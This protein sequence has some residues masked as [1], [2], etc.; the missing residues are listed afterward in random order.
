MSDFD[1]QQLPGLDTDTPTDQRETPEIESSVRKRL[2]PLGYERQHRLVAPTFRTQSPDLRRET[3]PPKRGDEDPLNTGLPYDK[4][5]PDGW[6]P[7]TEE[8]ASRRDAIDPQLRQKVER[9]VRA[10]VEVRSQRVLTELLDAVAMVQSRAPLGDTED[11]SRIHLAG[12]DI[13][14]SLGDPAAKE[15][16]EKVVT[17]LSAAAVVSLSDYLCYNLVRGDAQLTSNGYRP[18][19]L[20]IQGAAAKLVQDIAGTDAMVGAALIQRFFGADLLYYAWACI[21]AHAKDPWEARDDV[22]GLFRGQPITWGKWTPFALVDMLFGGEGNLSG[23]SA[24]IQGGVGLA[25]AC[26]VMGLW[27]SPNLL[28]GLTLRVST[29]VELPLDPSCT[30]LLSTLLLKYPLLETLDLSAGVSHVVTNSGDHMRATVKAVLTPGD[31]W[32]LEAAL[33]GDF[34]E[35]GSPTTSDKPYN[36]QIF[37]K[38]ALALRD[39]GLELQASTTFPVSRLGTLDYDPDETAEGRFDASYRTGS[40]WLGGNLGVT[41][42][43]PQGEL[44]ARWQEDGLRFGANLGYDPRQGFWGRGSLTLDDPLGRLFGRQEPRRR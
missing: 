24:L 8:D 14:A 3:T 31:V 43:G 28:P 10:L 25:L 42:L 18:V 6:R 12:A 22:V 34:H 4:S 23:T 30:A 33:G 40:L 41:H 44:G 5:G 11:P 7:E 35:S 36:V 13:R 9:I 1:G 39:A 26:L 16:W 19:Q 17:V 27:D 38:F 21:P 20:A 29:D 15:T 32:R 2:K 37:Q